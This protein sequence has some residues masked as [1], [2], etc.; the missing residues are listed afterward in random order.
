[1]EIESIIITEKHS[2]KSDSLKVL[3]RPVATTLLF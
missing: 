3:Y 1:M 2:T